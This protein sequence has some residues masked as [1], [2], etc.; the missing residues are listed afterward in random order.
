MFVF[1]CEC[2]RVFECEFVYVFCAYSN[3]SCYASK[4]VLVYVCVNVLV[5]VFV[6]LCF[7]L[8][9]CVCVCAFLSVYFNMYVCVRA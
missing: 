3:V 9:L 4:F 7:C 8:S 5:F 6:C 2:M 1:V